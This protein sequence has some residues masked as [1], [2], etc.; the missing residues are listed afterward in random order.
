MSLVHFRYSSWYR[1][2]PAISM[3]I[4]SS[5]RAT[6]M[7]VMVPVVVGVEEA[8]NLLRVGADGRHM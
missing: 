5:L 1:K 2:H 7:V 3:V 4:S 6:P 8:G